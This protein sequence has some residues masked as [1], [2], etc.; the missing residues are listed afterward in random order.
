MDTNPSLCQFIKY[1]TFLLHLLGIN[2][3]PIY[4]KNYYYFIDHKCYN[5]TEQTQCQINLIQY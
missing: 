2:N 4:L 3:H 5:N 1:S